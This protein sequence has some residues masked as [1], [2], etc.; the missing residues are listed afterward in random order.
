MDPSAEEAP[1]RRPSLEF[2]LTGKGCRSKVFDLFSFALGSLWP[3]LCSNHIMGATLKVY[4]LVTAGHCTSKAK[5]RVFTTLNA[6]RRSCQKGHQLIKQA[7][8]G[9]LLATSSLLTTQD[10]SR[11]H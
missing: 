2:G 8:R 9:R 6:H 7:Q 4:N 11:S 5:P 10:S 3:D 1:F